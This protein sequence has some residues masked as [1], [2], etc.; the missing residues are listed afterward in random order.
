VSGDPVPVDGAPDPADGAP[1]DPEAPVDPD[2]ALVDPAPA[3]EVLAG[4]KG[5]TAADYTCS[6]SNN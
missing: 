4:V 3:T 2:A 6:K 1:V 5:Q